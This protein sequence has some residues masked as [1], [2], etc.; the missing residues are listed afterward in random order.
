MK[1]DEIEQLHEPVD[2]NFA[3]KP[4]DP[5]VSDFV[6]SIDDVNNEFPVDETIGAK[7]IISHTPAV[8]EKSAQGQIAKKLAEMLYSG[9]SKESAMKS[10]GVQPHEINMRELMIETNS[11]LLS[12]YTFPDEARRLMVK[13]SLNK[14]LTEAIQSNDIDTILKASKQIASDPDV[15]LTAPPQNVINISLEKAQDALN[16]A[17]ERTEFDFNE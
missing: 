5:V 10:L 9:I 14:V 7:V 15:G 3:N 11:F 12:T 17:N 16:K 1:K 13:A 8:S 4:K 2:T 6:K